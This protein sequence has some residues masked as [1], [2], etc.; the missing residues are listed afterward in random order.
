MAIARCG[1]C[2]GDAEVAGRRY[3]R[4]RRAVVGWLPLLLAGCAAGGQQAAEP[5]LTAV[6]AGS[7][8]LGEPCRIERAK[9]AHA[10]EAAAFEIFCGGWE[11]PSARVVRV[12]GGAAAAEGD[13]RNR[14]DAFAACE[15]PQPVTV[16][17]DAPALSLS[18][19]IRRGGWAYQALVARIGETTFLGDSIPAT[20]PVLER[21]IGL[22]AG[23]GTS[24]A[25]AGQE[26]IR[27]PGRGGG[28]PRLYSAG[29]LASYRQLLHQAQYYNHQGDYPEAEKLYRQALTL[30]QQWASASEGGL[31]YVLMSLA[32]ELSNQERFAEAQ[33]FFQQAETLVAQSLDPTD[34][35]RLTSYRALDLANQRRFQRAGELARDASAQRRELVRQLDP[36][37]GRRGD[38]ADPAALTIG[39][40]G[41]AARAGSGSLSLV[42]SG[43]T[44]LGDVVQSQY[45]EA[46]MLVRADKLDAAAAALAEARRVLDG[47]RRV[48][49]RWRPQILSLEALI[50][51][52]LGDLAAAERLLIDSVAG[53]RDVA[54]GSRNEALTL[55]D[56]GRVQARAG[57]PATALDSYRAAF[58]LIRAGNDG[59]R[60]DD[61]WPFFQLMLAAA[62]QQTA[63]QQAAARQQLFSEMFQVGQLIRSTQTAQTIALAS[64][65]L[66]AS[67]REVGQLIRSL[68]DARRQRD[69][70]SQA[71]AE[72]RANPATLAPQLQ[73]LEDRW[74]GLAATVA[75]VE[76]QVQA[77]A[78][79][80]NQIIDT[81]TTPA[82]VLQALRGDEALY[83]IIVGSEQALAFYVDSEGIEAFAVA[84]GEREATTAVT[85]LRVPFDQV[86]GA[87]FDA[88]R[89]HD[90]YRRLF[91]PVA[92]RLAGR[93]HL[94][95]VPSGVLATLPFGVLVTQPPPSATDYPAVAWLA[96]RQAVSL[97]P[98]VQSFVSLRSQVRP[99]RATKG[100]IGFGDFVPDRDVRATLTARG[101]PE[102]C[103]DAVRAVAEMSRLPHS[104]AELQSVKA[105]LGPA[106]SS[107]WLRQEF[108]EARVKRA[109]LADYRVVYFATHALLPH[110]F[111]CWAEPVLLTSGPAA[112]DTTEDGF[113]VA[114]EIAELGLDADLVVLSA[115]NTASPQGGAGGDSLSG[116]ARAF[117]YAGARSLLVTHWPIPDRPTERLMSRLFGDLAAQ[118]LSVAEALRQAQVALIADP[119]LAHPFNWA[120]FSVVGDGGQRLRSAPVAAREADPGAAL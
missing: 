39:A 117:F 17:G 112:G 99:S 53:Y 118:D 31:A 67:D 75:E 16:L 74:R 38:D 6:D 83:Q 19:A 40:K 101:L 102:A 9:A 63:A 45:L 36:T 89:A 34:A 14:I 52:R 71:L 87:P 60:F 69:Q 94:I 21:S 43:E 86:I 108:T 111:N 109:P 23:R 26:A 5:T 77:A 11:Q 72:A 13:W 56:L 46:A 59:V 107:I 35:A 106:E 64:A 18:C 49:R 61:A 24:D 105:A 76:R 80:Y 51:E 100:M 57:Q 115:C 42:G 97:A 104:A 68:Q 65:R 92:A 37:A 22:L 32:L 25:P 44:A 3:G 28:A 98:S 73:A 120:A 8:L 15:P 66:S 85:L 50:A 47:D 82:T 84:L 78:P 119:Q 95:S 41:A 29:D 20:A 113:L 88:A 27:P 55:L 103:R 12:A 33:A 70:V 96:K 7:N 62:A 48:P 1:G 93:R 2:R 91:E 10:G 81:P 116:L 4:N 58:A 54:A 79:R 90:L 30:Q 114:S 110:D